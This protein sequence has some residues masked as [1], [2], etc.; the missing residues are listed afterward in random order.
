MSEIICLA[1]KEKRY[2]SGAASDQ[3]EIEKNG[4]TE[5]KKISSLNYSTDFPAC[6]LRISRDHTILKQGC[7]IGARDPRP[8]VI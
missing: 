3:V 4:E 8:E 7:E 6:V 2:L 5:Y 1:C